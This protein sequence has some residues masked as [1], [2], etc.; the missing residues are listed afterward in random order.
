MLL[1]KNIQNYGQG[2][3]IGILNK[4]QI[5][6]HQESNICMYKES[7]HTI[8]DMLFYIEQFIIVVDILN[9]VANKVYYD[10]S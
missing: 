5:T 9:F 1:I 7:H 6:F 2:S 10:F 8:N 4:Q 3:M